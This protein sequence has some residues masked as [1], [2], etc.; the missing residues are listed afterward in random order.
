MSWPWEWVGEAWND[1]SGETDRRRARDAKLSA[2][3][4]AEA[5]LEDAQEKGI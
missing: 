2:A 3:E 4:R 5:R 1:L